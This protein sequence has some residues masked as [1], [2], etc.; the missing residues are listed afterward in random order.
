VRVT[1][2]PF[3]VTPNVPYVL[4]FASW[5]DDIQSGFIGVMVNGSPIY[6]VDAGDKGA[7]AWHANT[8]SYTPTTATIALRFEFLFGTQH[9]PS[10]QMVDSVTFTLA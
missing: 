3:A 7:G 2:E 5:F 9:V 1:S 10:V 8:V 4:G 6:T